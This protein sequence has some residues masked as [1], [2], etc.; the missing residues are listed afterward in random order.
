MP[1][2][3]LTDNGDVEQYPYTLTD[4][5]ND[6][7]NVSFSSSITDVE[8]LEFNVVSVESVEAPPFVYNKE[9]VRTIEQNN[10][11]VYTEVWAYT[12]ADPLTISEREEAEAVIV[13]LRRDQLLFSSDWTQLS[14]SPVDSSSWAVYRQALR[15]IPSQKGFPWTI[16]W[17][18][19][20]A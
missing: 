3:K 8:L 10:D 11:G 20:P 9:L 17:P 6:N 13:R 7:S 18:I 1:Y 14:D 16:T 5:K 19:E 12:D 15:D 4:L 2:A